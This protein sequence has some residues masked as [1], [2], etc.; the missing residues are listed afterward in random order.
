M[1]INKL[2]P[3]LIISL[4]SISEVYSEQNDE[5][6]AKSQVDEDYLIED[7][8][9]EDEDSR[10]LFSLNNIQNDIW[11]DRF[12]NG[13]SSI[14]LENNNSGVI[15]LLNNNSNIKLGSDEYVITSSNMPNYD[16][17][18]V[19]VEDISQALSSNKEN[20]EIKNQNLLIVTND[21]ENEI[22]IKSNRLS[23]GFVC[24]GILNGTEIWSREFCEIVQGFKIDEISCNCKGSFIY[25]FAE[26][27]DQNRA[28]QMQYSKF[29]FPEFGSGGNIQAHHVNDAYLSRVSRNDDPNSNHGDK[30]PFPPLHGSIGGRSGNVNMQKKETKKSPTNN[31]ITFEQNELMQYYHSGSTNKYIINNQD[32][33]HTYDKS[34]LNELN[35]QNSINKETSQINSDLIENNSIHKNP[36]NVNNYNELIK[37]SSSISNNNN[38]NNN[39]NN[40]LHTDFSTPKV[41][42]ITINMEIKNISFDS[43][44]NLLYKQSFISKFINSL[45]KALNLI[46]NKFRI[47]NIWNEENPSLRRGNSGSIGITINIIT[48]SPDEIITKVKNLKNQICEF[49][50]IFDFYLISISKNIGLK[51]VSNEIITDKT[52]EKKEREINSDIESPRTLPIIF[53]MNLRTRKPYINQKEAFTLLEDEL[54]KSMKI[55]KSSIDIPEFTYKQ[56]NDPLTNESYLMIHTEIWVHP[57]KQIREEY[58]SLLTNIY[59]NIIHNKR[60]SFSS[61]FLCSKHEIKEIPHIRAHP[62]ED[63]QTSNQVNNSPEFSGEK[64]GISKETEPIDEGRIS[65]IGRF[66]LINQN[67]QENQSNPHSKKAESIE[68]IQNEYNQDTNESNQINPVI[69]LFKE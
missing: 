34:K 54:S 37:K 50:K 26:S 45:S 35:H 30:V 9:T 5:Y 22:L 25:S 61:I 43:L 16:S 4:L 2:L 38:N 14:E 63:E 21:T 32:G 28:L 40:K 60:S 19:F 67:R 64:I 44:N 13:F 8:D 66:Y 52:K 39:N 47:V 17:L 36:W 18:I 7:F 27:R 49:S 56:L 65:K 42:S 59:S 53:T 12:V 68:N 15:H 62:I 51:S 3:F 69:Y 29:N 46:P 1:G 33:S 31:E 23:N 20:R 10:Y 48:S 24:M 11:S 57:E 55:P 41:D 6:I 58:T